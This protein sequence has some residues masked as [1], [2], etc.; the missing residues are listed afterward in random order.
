MSDRLNAA[1]G[2]ALL[3]AAGSA[4]NTPNR[5]VVTFIAEFVSVVQVAAPVDES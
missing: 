4:V 3:L 5:V 2:V 1:P